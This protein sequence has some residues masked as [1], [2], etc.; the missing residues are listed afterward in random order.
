M[1]NLAQDTDGFIHMSR[2]LPRKMSIAITFIDGSRSEFSGA[3]LNELY[4]QALAAYRLGNNLDAKGF[5]RSPVKIHRR[6][7]VGLVPVSPDMAR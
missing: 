4:D 3:R 6:D 2:H 5:D 7:G 1:L